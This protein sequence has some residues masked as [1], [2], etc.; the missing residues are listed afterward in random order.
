MSKTTNPEAAGAHLPRRLFYYNAGFWR[1]KRLRRILE[2]SGHELRLGRPREG[3]GVVVWGRSPYAKRG[4]AVAARS[5]APL[6]RLEDAFLRSL[7]PGRAGE[8]PQGLMIDGRGVH[9]DSSQPSE[10]EHILANTP[11]D[12]S[13]TL[14]I[15]KGGIERLREAH[16]T[17][18]SGFDTNAPLPEAG[19]VLVIDQTRGDASV[20]HGKADANAFREALY[21]AQEDN[22]GARIVVKTHP[23]TAQGFRQGYFSSKDANARITLF[24]APVS[25]HA[26]LDGAIAVYTVSSQMGFEAIMAGHKP[27]VFGQPFYAGWGL[28]DDRC[29]HPLP[30]RGRALTPAQL[31]AGAMVLAPTWYSA[32]DDKLCSF[33]QALGEFE[34]NTRAWREDHLGWKAAHMRLWKRKPLQQFFGQHGK[35]TFQD[36]AEGERA[37]VWA[38]KATDTG[39]G[40]GTG[41]GTNTDT[42]TDSRVRV[43]DGFLRSRGLGAKLTPP[44]SLVLDDM[45][46]YYDPT[47]ESRLELLIKTRAKLRPDQTLRA[48]KLIDEITAKGVTKYN[49]EGAVPALPEGRKLLVPGQVE[50][51]AS[52]KLG[53]GDVNTNLKLLQAA[54][55]ANPAAIIVFKPHPDVEAGLRQGTVPADQLVGLA[56]VLVENASAEALLAAVD[57]VWTMTSLLGFEALLRGKKVTTT[58][59]PFY[60][61]WGLTTDKGAACERRGMHIQL[62]SLVHAALID[63]PRYHD[64]V[65]NLPCTAE[66]AVKRLASGDGLSR[67]PV[68]KGLSKLQ[69]LFASYAH[70]WR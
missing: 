44:L 20:T 63:Y 32:I 43:E 55:N 11:L 49:L 35:L 18:Y 17:K 46:I 33:E 19:Y 56:D 23:E 9:F 21:Y 54:R 13:A 57:E 30:R 38:G 6:V 61:G 39:T 16:L 58:G 36:K 7:K 50:D 2:L 28:T 37:M 70:L 12:D 5:A 53:A 52:I 29:P 24:D 22:P 31:F 34:A 68:N 1:Q 66:T 10:I 4:E 14:A 48:R 69:G 8:P 65:S 67:G 59:R 51:D 15:A 45:G 47:F 60:A 26:L 25:P 64:P 27:V 40:T 3:D 62:E 42:N 41:T